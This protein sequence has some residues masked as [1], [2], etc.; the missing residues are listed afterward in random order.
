LASTQ[1]PHNGLIVANIPARDNVNSSSWGHPRSSHT[2]T[3]EQPM[4]PIRSEKISTIEEDLAA[5]AEVEAG[6]RDFVRGDVANLRRPASLPCS[7]D[8]ALEPSTE[9]AV[10][11]IN[12]LIERVAGPSLTE[13]GNLI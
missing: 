9:A 6:I 4:N 1:V 11:N 5:V 10:N 8:T 7:T 13:I 12:S 2:S 3:R